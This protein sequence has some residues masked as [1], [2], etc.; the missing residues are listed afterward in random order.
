MLLNFILLFCLSYLFPIFFFS[1]LPIYDFFLSLPFEARWVSIHRDIFGCVPCFA[2]FFFSRTS[3][4]IN[5]IGGCCTKR[6]LQHHFAPRCHRRKKNW[7]PGGAIDK[8]CNDLWIYRITRF[9]LEKLFQ[10]VKNWPPNTCYK[11]KWDKEHW[12][13]FKFRKR[14]IVLPQPGLS[15]FFLFFSVISTVKHDLHGGQWC[16]L[17]GKK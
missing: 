9:I 13:N 15:Y 16:N 3:F 4:K 1:S 11:I 8:K 2:A 10:R 14:K 17:I 5:C 12:L 6:D 7:S